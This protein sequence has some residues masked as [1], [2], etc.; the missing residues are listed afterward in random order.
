[1]AVA[2]ALLGACG[3]GGS[4]GPAVKLDGSPRYPDDE[5]VATTVTANEVVL[6]GGRHYTVSDKLVSFSTYDHSVQPLV[7]FAKQYVQVGLKG[8]QV[9]WL[10]GIGAVVPGRP[11]AA[12]SVYYTGQ[13]QRVDAK[14]RIVFAD[15]TVL[16]LAPG[17]QA[18]STSA[19]QARIDPASHR[20][21]A[22]L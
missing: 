2:L 19:V 10:A 1:V 8:K 18:P 7:G 22:F 11:G 6:D 14:Q 15:G 12:P 13:P 3:R 20:V 9:V 16:Q 17:V 21:A 4:D 5:G